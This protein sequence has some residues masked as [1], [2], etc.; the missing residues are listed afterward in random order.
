MKPE[1]GNDIQIANAHRIPTRQKQKQKQKRE[2]SELQQQTGYIKPNPVIIKFV[3]MQDRQLVLS[4]AK[5]I[6][7]QKNISV[8]TDLPTHLKVRGENYLE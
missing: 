5:N 7:K 4:M 2:H 3:K 1:E 6:Y 8:C